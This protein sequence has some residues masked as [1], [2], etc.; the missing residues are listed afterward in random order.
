MTITLLRAVIIYFS[1]IFAVRIMGR[2]QV[3][4]LSN[5]E[6]VITILIS[7]VA[8]IPLEDNEIPLA[9][10]LL[11]ILIFIS[12]EVL[13][14]ALS[15]KSAW[16]RDK[17]QGKPFVIIKDGRLNQNAM[18]SL[19]ITVDDILDTLRQ[20]DV[21]DISEVKNAV[22]ETNG[23]LS[24]QKKDDNGVFP[25]PVITDGAII[26]EYF[27][28]DEIRESEIRLHLTNSGYSANEIMLLTVDENG[29]LF[30]IK[31]EK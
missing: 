2:R 31:K 19:R 18:K 26:S 20:K 10:S 27:A 29:R 9:N 7:A 17:L 11:P 6:F 3:G 5:H 12:F 23:S 28:R 16:F 4:E 21:F 24:V 14:S 30:V 25:I 22:I 1:V 15:M 8:T 13:V